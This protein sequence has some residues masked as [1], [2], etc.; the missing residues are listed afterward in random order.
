MDC[1]L[2][3]AARDVACAADG[4]QR[5]CADKPI[6]R[7]ETKAILE[8]RL[9]GLLTLLA[10]SFLCLPRDHAQHGEVVGSGHDIGHILF[11]ADDASEPSAD[12]ELQLRECKDKAPMASLVWRC[13]LSSF[14]AE[15]LRFSSLTEISPAFSRRSRPCRCQ[16][17]CPGIN[18]VI[19][20]TKPSGRRTLRRLP[21]SEPEPVPLPGGTATCPVPS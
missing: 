3:A 1:A 10:H 7:V 11:K 13:S 8:E 2:E 18:A 16:Q 14:A 12:S 19:M 5:V 6:A 9:D 21:R 15:I 20:M 4:P 17:P